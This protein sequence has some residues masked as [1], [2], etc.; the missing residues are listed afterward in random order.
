MKSMMRLLVFFSLYFCGIYAAIPPVEYDPLLVV[1]IMVK[2]EETVMRATLQPYVDGGITSYLVLD[3]GSTDRTVEVT[4]EFFE[5]HSITNFFIA[6]EPF[7]N[8]E[9][10]R[11]RALDLAEEKF[12]HAAFMIMPDAEWY[13]NDAKALVDFCGVCLQRRDP[14]SSYLVHIVNKFLDNYTSRLLRCRRNVRFGGVVHET[15]TQATPAKVPDTIYFEYLPEAYGIEKTMARLSRDRKL[16]E[17]E[18]NKKPWCT[19]TLFYLARTCEDLG[20]L[21]AAYNYYKIRITMRGWDE[22]D[23]IVRHRLAETIKKLVCKERHP[24]FE[25][26]EALMYYLQAHQMRPQ[27]IEPLVAIADYYVQCG[28]MKNAFLFALPAAKA[29]YPERETLFV[30]KYIYDYYRYEM[31]ARCAWYIGEFEEGEYAACKAYE[32]CPE[33]E[34][35]RFNVECYLS[36][37]GQTLAKLA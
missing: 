11:N 26:G 23:F 33:Y 35:A 19:R 1:V 24:D 2:N 37:K 28:E 36:R 32:A 18:Y 20:D 12:P 34:H 15:I 22:E 17:E 29:A 9:V 4:R 3:T 27:R 31:L 5:E 13:L 25:W 16:L 21:V 14:Y 10:S 30:E 6:E 7:V 8:F